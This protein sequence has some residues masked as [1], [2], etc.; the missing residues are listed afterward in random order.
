MTASSAVTTISEEDDSDIVLTATR[1][2]NAKASQRG[3]WNACTVD[4]PKQSL[5]GCRSLVNPAAMG[6]AGQAAARIADGLAL[7]WEGDI[8]AAIGRFDQAIAIAP[9]SAFAYLNRGLAKRRIGDLDGALAD[10]DRAVLH[11]RTS[12]RAYYNRSRVLRERGD[13]RRARADEGRA[14]DLDPDYGE[15]V[16]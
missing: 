12:A 6:A 3:D 10:L 8:E 5:S 9:K 2:G 1:R 15:I 7:A 14:V 13:A 4:D 11:A 16:E